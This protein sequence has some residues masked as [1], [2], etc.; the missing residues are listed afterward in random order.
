MESLFPHEKSSFPVNLSPVAVLPLVT[1]DTLSM[2]AHSLY[3][4]AAQIPEV[5]NRAERLSVRALADPMMGL[6]ELRASRRL[7]IN[8]IESRIGT[9]PTIDDTLTQSQQKLVHEESCATRENKRSRSICLCC[10][11]QPRAPGCDLPRLAVVSSQPWDVIFSKHV[12][13][14]ADSYRRLPHPA[15]LHIIC[16]LI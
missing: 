5:P 12:R 15:P 9:R 13:K 7:D 14:V 16:N 10:K 6:L 2:I 3:G 4:F 8:L 11:Y 1:T